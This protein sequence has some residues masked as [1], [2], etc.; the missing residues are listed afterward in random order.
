M[1]RGSGKALITSIV[2]HPSNNLIACTSNRT[3]IHLF[4]IK[5]SIEKSGDAKAQPT[6]TGSGNGSALESGDNKKSK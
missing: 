3:S 1:R 2:F 5:K 6:Q 4:E